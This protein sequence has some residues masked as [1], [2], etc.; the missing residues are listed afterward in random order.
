MRSR[1]GIYTYTQREGD[2]YTVKL[3]VYIHREREG[4]TLESTVVYT[5]RE[6]DTH[7]DEIQAVLY[8]FF[9]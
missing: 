4:D 8:M 1:K 5:C 2:T 7:T 9:V 3:R 6:R